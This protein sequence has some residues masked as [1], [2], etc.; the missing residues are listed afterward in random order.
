VKYLAEQIPPLDQPKVKIVFRDK[1]LRPPSSFGH[2]DWEVDIW[3]MSNFS[4]FWG[5]KS[6]LGLHLVMKTEKERSVLLLFDTMPGMKSGDPHPKD[7]LSNGGIRG[8]DKKEIGHRKV[9]Q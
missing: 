7:K 4:C 9:K 5:Q 6:A 8:K 2:G 1:S 3:M